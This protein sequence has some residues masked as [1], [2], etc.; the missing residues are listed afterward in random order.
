MA[1]EAVG[2]APTKESFKPLTEHQ[3]QTP[4]TFFGGQPILYL[5]CPKSRVLVSKSQLEENPLLKDL[6][7]TASSEVEGSDEIIIPDVDIWVSSQ[8]LTLFAPQKSGISIS[9]PSIALHALGTHNSP[10]NAGDSGQ[11]VFLQVN[12]H[13]QDTINSDDDIKTLDLSLHVTDIAQP[14]QQ[15]QADGSEPPSAVKALFEALSTC[16]DL[17]PDPEEQG[18]DAEQ[19]P[20]PG[21][22]GWI[23]AENM[24]DFMDADGNFVGIGTLGAGA[25]AVHARQDDDEHE[26]GVN[27]KEETEETKWQRTE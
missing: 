5:H 18:S 15:P 11:V 12:L 1:I 7:V 10:S 20:E 16:A 9:Y 19:E 26:N 27:G 23:T 2:T 13:N 22:G 4:E 17:H 6:Q 14:E 21:A 25:G 8:N 3:A 24:N